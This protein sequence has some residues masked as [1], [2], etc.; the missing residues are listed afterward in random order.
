MKIKNFQHS[1]LACALFDQQQKKIEV[2][3]I[4]SSGDSNFSV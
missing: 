3:F 4:L 1:L 2:L